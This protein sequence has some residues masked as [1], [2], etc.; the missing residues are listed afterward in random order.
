MNTL[1]VVC[2]GACALLVGCAGAC[3]STR[4]SPAGVAA[5]VALDNAR[6]AVAYC[7]ATRDD[8]ADSV[9]CY[10][11]FIL[12]DCT[13]DSECAAFNGGEY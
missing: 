9:P 2:A 3:A 12:G 8:I 5:D 13:S 6:R 7:D 10:N 11:R 4:V 1:S